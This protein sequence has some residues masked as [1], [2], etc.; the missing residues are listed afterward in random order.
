MHSPISV[1][2]NFFQCPTVFSK[3]NQKLNPPHF[4]PQ[5]FCLHDS[6]S[7]QCKLPIVGAVAM[8]YLW[9]HLRVF[10]YLVHN[11]PCK[12]ER[13]LEVDN[14]KLFSATLQQPIVHNLDRAEFTEQEKL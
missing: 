5:Q 10:F 1:F 6:W 7:Q 13:C 14:N 11:L 12:S 2:A 9:S 4:V 8:R 3:Q